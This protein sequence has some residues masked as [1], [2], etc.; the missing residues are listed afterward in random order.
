MRFG[1]FLLKKTKKN[2]RNYTFRRI[3]I[4]KNKKK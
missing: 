3:F 4:K 2:C 1:V